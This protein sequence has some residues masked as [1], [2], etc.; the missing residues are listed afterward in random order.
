[1]LDACSLITS[2]KA[3]AVLGMNVDPGTVAAPGANSCIWVDS[4]LATSSVEIAVNNVADFNPAQK[5]IPGLTITPV[6]GVGDAAYYVNMSPGYVV[7]KVRKGQNAFTTS[8]ILHGASDSERMA[9]EKTLAMDVLA[10][11]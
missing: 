2:G 3:E 5:S 6:S 11:I 8:V 10:R 4:K 9:G 1:V 7:L